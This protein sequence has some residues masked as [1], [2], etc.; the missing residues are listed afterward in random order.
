MKVTISATWLRLPWQMQQWDQAYDYVIKAG[1]GDHASRVGL[2]HIK[3]AAQANNPAA[4]AVKA[5]FDA[6]AKLVTAG[7]PKPSVFVAQQRRKSP[8]LPGAPGAPGT[9]ARGAAPVAEPA[10]I[11][12]LAATVKQQQRQLE[13]QRKGFAAKQRSQAQARAAAAKRVAARRAEQEQYETELEMLR[14]QLERRDLADEIRA[15][16]EAQAEHYEGLIEALKRPAGEAEGTAVTEGTAAEQPEAERDDVA[17][18]M[19]SGAP[20][21]VEFSNAGE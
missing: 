8:L 9:P 12:K 20:G 17:E 13:Q 1:G 18:A 21:D 14:T 6:V 3:Y 10:A 4:K 7:L 5:N 2:G 15:K 11:R 16:L 19:D